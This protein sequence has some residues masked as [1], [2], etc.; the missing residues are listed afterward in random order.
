[1]ARRAGLEPGDIA[2]TLPLREFL[3]TLKR[4]KTASR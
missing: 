4:A 1:V 3:R 2:N